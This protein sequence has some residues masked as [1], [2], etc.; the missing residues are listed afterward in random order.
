MFKIIHALLLAL[1][2]VLLAAC[3]TPAIVQQADS[4]SENRAKTFQ[5][6]AAKGK[7]YFVNGQ[8]TYGGFLT[9]TH[10]YPSDFIVNDKVIASMNKENVLV[11][12]LVPGNYEFSWMPR[13][14]DPIDK[15]SVPNK[16]KTRV[17]GGKI[18]ILRGDYS[19][20]GAMAFGLIGSMVSPP[21]TSI[22][23]GAKNDIL[24]KTVV[25]PQ[26]CPA[27]MCIK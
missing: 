4:D 5:V 12:D 2:T 1:V 18:V 27:A 8:I 13:S 23:F 9:Q 14:S 26:N 17:D 7:I 21:Q 11:F 16:L 20:G 10:P 15:N 22:V 19:L 6:D 25:M 24:N 3:Q